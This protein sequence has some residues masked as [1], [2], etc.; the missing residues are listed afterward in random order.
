MDSGDLGSRLVN[1]AKHT[2]ATL[3]CLFSMW[4]VHFVLM[5]LLGPDWQV[6]DRVPIRYFIDA[7][8]VTILVKLVWHLFREFA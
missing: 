2:V 4:L 3:A 1:I 5:L 7:G 6:F 8:E